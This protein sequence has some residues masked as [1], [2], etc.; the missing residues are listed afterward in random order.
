MPEFTS[1]ENALSIDSMGEYYEDVEVTEQIIKKQSVDKSQKGFSD[2]LY[3]LKEDIK[4]NYLS[5]FQC[6]LSVKDCAVGEFDYSK[7]SC[8]L[9]C[10]VAMIDK[11]GNIVSN[12]R[13][14]FGGTARGKGNCSINW[15]DGELF[16]IDRCRP[17]LLTIDE[18][19]DEIISILS[20]EMEHAIGSLSSQWGVS[21]NIKCVQEGDEVVC[22]VYRS[23][24]YGYA[25]DDEQME[26]EYD[27]GD[28]IF[29]RFKGD[30][31]KLEALVPEI[32]NRIRDLDFWN[33]ADDQAGVDV[34]IEIGSIWTELE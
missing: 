27:Q 32:E 3:S 19:V 6:D 34:Q 18:A 2:I 33:D 28:K 14:R 25:L 31:K 4:Y 29:V 23:S 10:D 7:D 9:R 11:G 16:H 1:R 12:G 24:G 22:S 5:D 30:I 15:L 26:Y 20:S 8:E 17:S 13:I 21:G